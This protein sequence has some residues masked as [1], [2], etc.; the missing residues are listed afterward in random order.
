MSRG[1]RNKEDKFIYLNKV[2]SEKIRRVRLQIADAEV[3]SISRH[4]SE[5]QKSTEDVDKD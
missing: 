4:D 3:N 2:W 5:S 1:R